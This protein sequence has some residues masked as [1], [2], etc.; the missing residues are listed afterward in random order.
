MET[1]SLA[2]F[3]GSKIQPHQ[4]RKAKNTCCDDIEG[5]VLEYYLAGFSYLLETKTVV[6][7]D[8]VSLCLDCDPNLRSPTVSGNSQQ[9]TLHRGADWLMWLHVGMFSLR[10]NANIELFL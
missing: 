10:N 1:A 3:K 8:L 2:L 6:F 5:C 9:E 7:L 4:S